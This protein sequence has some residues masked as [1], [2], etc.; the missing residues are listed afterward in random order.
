MSAVFALTSC[1]H[2]DTATSGSG[3]TSLSLK[4]FYK[5][6]EESGISENIPDTSD[7]ILT[8]IDCN[9][10]IIYDARYGDRPKKMAIPSGKTTFG[11]FSYRFT[12]PDFNKP[13][14][15]DV[16][17]QEIKAGTSY[18]V[19]FDCLQLSCGVRIRC[20][21]EFTSTYPNGV[22]TVRW[23]NGEEESEAIHYPYGESRYLHFKPGE[24]M[25]FFDKDGD[26]ADSELLTG[27]ILASADMLNINLSITPE[28]GSGHFSIT[29]D[30]LT[31]QY[32]EKYTY[33][34]G[35]DGSTVYRAIYVSDI[36]RFAGDTIWMTGFVVGSYRNSKF[37]PG[38]TTA[39]SNIGIAETAD[40]TDPEAVVPIGFT[41]GSKNAALRQ[42]LGQRVY[43]AGAVETYFKRLGIKKTK[44]YRIINAE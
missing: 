42:Y 10:E 43:V 26:G 38:D 16:K 25:I 35:R 6:A 9:G 11:I 21:E 3:S 32:E 28:S 31:E 17:E 33:G 41:S 1:S 36:G 19:K 2:L 29:I 15:G 39:T 44:E 23:Q 40:E 24:V 20:S 18:T 8:V 22:L 13:L 7:F 12:K 4:S 30:T 27:R 37:Y 34:T 14:Y 5:Q